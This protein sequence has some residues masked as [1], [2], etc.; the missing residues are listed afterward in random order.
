MMKTPSVTAAAVGVVRPTTARRAPQRPPTASG[1]QQQQPQPAVMVRR[2]TFVKDKDETNSATAVAA[3][4]QDQDMDDE[5]QAAAPPRGL[6]FLAD[7]EADPAAGS[8]S[9]LDA[10][11][12]ADNEDGNN[13]GQFG[14]GILQLE[15]GFGS[16]DS[17]SRENGRKLVAFLMVYPKKLFLI[18]ILQSP[19]PYSN[20][21]LIF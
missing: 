21:V 13:V 17:H 3:A 11:S 4:D 5:L 1:Q 16:R 10:I 19:L 14:S 7:D 18:I 2:N 6:K 15:S 8:P 9:L 20:S 12:F